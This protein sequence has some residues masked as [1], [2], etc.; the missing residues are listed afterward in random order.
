LLRLVTPR[1]TPRVTPGMFKICRICQGCYA[2][3]PQPPPRPRKENW[4]PSSFQP[5]AF[6][7]QPCGREP[8][9][10][11]GE[12]GKAQSLGKYGFVTPGSL[13]SPPAEKMRLAVFSP[14]SLILHPSSLS[15]GTPCRAEVRR[16]SINPQPPKLHSVALS[17]AQF[18]QNIFLTPSPR[19]PPLVRQ[20]TWF[21]AEEQ[22]GYRTAQYG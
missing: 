16:R 9:S 2:V 1:V 19:A 20:R 18:H 6:S 17:C 10:L 12:P 22:D 7:L 21:P 13:E 5:S 11:D 14:S 8:G 3:T 4:P 15:P